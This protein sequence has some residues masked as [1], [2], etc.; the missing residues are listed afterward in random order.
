VVTLLEVRSGALRGFK[1][2]VLARFPADILR[3]L[4]V[5]C[6]ATLFFLLSGDGPEAPHV[7]AINVLATVAALAVVEI[8]LRKRQAPDD[9]VPTEARLPRREWS[10]VG[11]QLLLVAGFGLVLAQTDTLM[12]GALRDTTDAGIYAVAS[13]LAA[14]CC[15]AFVSVEV[16][17][18]PQIAELHAGGRERELQR[19]LRLGARVSLMFAAPVGVTLVVGS[20]VLLGWFGPEFMQGRAALTVLAVGQ[21]VNCFAGSVVV[22]MTM[23]GQQRFLAWTLGGMAA[24]NVALNGALIPRYGMFGAAVA[25]TATMVLWNAVLVVRSWTALGYDTTALGMRFRRR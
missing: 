21:L 16:M 1:R 17:I 6:G 7:V 9:N 25:T 12:L 19:V 2:V 11:F 22:L 24:A 8:A 20:A 10:S 4:F 3:H 13:R 14:F 18:G 5:G 15:F 23:T